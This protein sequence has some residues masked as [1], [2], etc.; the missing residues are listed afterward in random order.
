MATSLT[1]PRPRADFRA[2]PAR[3]NSLAH[4]IAL[5]LVWLTVAVSS[6]VA[7]EPAPVDALTAGLFI[8]LP[9]IGL[10]DAKPRL[11]AGLMFWLPIAALTLL[12]ATRAFNGPA[13]VTHAAVTLY[14]YGAA[15]L[16]ACF[17]A[18][19]PGAHTRLILSAYL[20]AAVIA[21]CL[22]IAGYLDLLPGA[23]D[24]LTE[25]DRASAL[26]KDPNVYGPFLI[27][28]LLTAMH[29]A[30][31]RPTSRVLA[32]LLLAS[33]LVLGILFSFSRG[34]WAAAVLAAALYCYLYTLTA[35]RDIER[36]KLAGFVLLS[37]AL[38]GLLVAAALQSD[39]VAR[40]IQERATLTQSYDEGPDGR[41]GGQ[42]KAI[43]VILSNPLG[44]GP[45]Q[46]APYYHREEA[47]NVYLTMIMNAGW[48]GGLLYLALCL[49][50]LAHGFNH[51]F[52]D[53]RTRPLFLI[54]YCSLAATILLGLIIDSDHWRHFYLLMGIVWGIMTGDPRAYRKAAI[55]ADR[56][57]V[58]LQKVL[59]VP[60]GRR[61]PRIAGRVPARAL[62]VLPPRPERRISAK[63]P[64]RIQPKPE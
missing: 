61:A 44:I 26:F 24:L 45:V 1:I 54:V 22:G 52:K 46:F 58:L 41:F 18:K 37:T 31:T 34:A 10:V 16:F 15:F 14:L 20:F 19:R 28:G 55:V 53:T 50:T 13:S 43:D 62:P 36:L 5:A 30:L 64:P 39:S 63:R 2:V 59:L 3:A 21:A 17:V 27:P 40:F 60:P 8:L 11:I 7:T 38:L 35:K 32:P 29:M 23:Y 25:Y 9:V 6:I 51:A 42:M 33:L 49:L 57:P 47:H 12:S 4:K 56:R 48:T